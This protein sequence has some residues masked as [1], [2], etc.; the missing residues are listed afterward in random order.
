MKNIF[1]PLYF[2]DP[3][4][5]QIEYTVNPV[6]ITQYTIVI[7]GIKQE[8]ICD[9]YYKFHRLEF[10][11]KHSRKIIK[12]IDSVV[13]PEMIILYVDKDARK[14]PYNKCVLIS[15]LDYSSIIHNMC[16]FCKKK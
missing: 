3:Y 9:S 2:A 5:Q 10:R 6:E 16:V 7:L 8:S 12:V 4:N 11:C 15:K 14:Y 1:K 13:T